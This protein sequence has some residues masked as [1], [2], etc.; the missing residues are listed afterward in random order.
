MRTCGSRCVERLGSPGTLSI[1]TQP[2][3][4]AAPESPLARDAGRWIPRSGVQFPLGRPHRGVPTCCSSA[5]IRPCHGRDPGSNPDV[6]VNLWDNGPARWR[7]YSSRQVPSRRCIHTESFGGAGPGRVC[8]LMVRCGIPDRFGGQSTPARRRIDIQPLSGRWSSGRRS[9]PWV[10][11]TEVR[12]L[13]DPLCRDWVSGNPAA[14]Y[15]VAVSCRPPGSTPG[16]G[17]LASRASEGS[18]EFAP[19]VCGEAGR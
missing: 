4:C 11:E 16:R 13:V 10:H 18:S 3:L 14:C 19:T 2:R 1:H 7:G 15:A 6:G 8:N 9:V 17:V 12:I 5:S